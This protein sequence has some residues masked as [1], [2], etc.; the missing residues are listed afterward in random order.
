[1]PLQI[2]HE[3][4]TF[5]GILAAPA[6]VMKC[7]EARAVRWPEVWKFYGSLTLLHLTTGGTNDE[8][9]VSVDTARGKDNDQQNLF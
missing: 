8:H 5:C 3:Y 6:F 9:S 1:M 4:T 7:I 2:I